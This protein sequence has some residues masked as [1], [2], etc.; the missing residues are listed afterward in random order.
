[1]K[2]ETETPLETNELLQRI[3]KAVEPGKPKRKFEVAAAVIL[4]IA[5]MASAWCAYQSKLWGGAQASRAGAGAQATREMAVKTIAAVQLRAFDASM[6]IAYVQAHFESNRSAEAFLAHRFRPDF[7][8]AVDAWL[9]LD[10]FNNPSAP[11]SPLQ[12][13]EY[14][15]KEVDEIARAQTVAEDA[16]RRAR[17][18]RRYSDSYVLLTVLFASVLF[19]GGISRAFQAP[20]LSTALSLLS[21]T[22]FLITIFAMLR[23]PVCHE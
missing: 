6:F 12:M 13:E 2:L 23:L 5:T 15:Q 9:K 3:L 20:R 4:S 11:P 19:F 14:V 16:G 17:D 22:L 1:M 8:P 18:A 10:G 21:L 7:K